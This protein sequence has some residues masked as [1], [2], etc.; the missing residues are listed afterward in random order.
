M[1]KKVL[2]IDDDKIWQDLWAR[3]LTRLVGSDIVIYK[4][5]TIEEGEK[6]FF[7][8][9]KLAAVAIDAC[10]PGSVVNTLP[11]VKKIREHFSG[12]MI[13]ISS[14]ETYQKKLIEAGCNYTCEKGRL[15]QKL[16]EILR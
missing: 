16:V 4:A 14:I 15:A 10:I 9:S 12:P 11:L 3:G 1:A 6:R 13:A 7:T 5:L 2:V 8:S